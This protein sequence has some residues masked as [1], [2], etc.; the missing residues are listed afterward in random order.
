MGAISRA[1]ETGAIAHGYASTA[2]GSNAIALGVGSKATHANSVAIGKGSST[3]ASDQITFGTDN[4]SIQ[5]PG[6]TTPIDAYAVIATNSTGVLRV[7]SFAAANLP[8]SYCLTSAADATCYGQFAD[9]TGVST[10]AIGA[11]SNANSGTDSDS[12]FAATAIGAHTKATGQ[13][14]TALGTSARATG[15]GSVSTG[16]NSS[17]TGPG[18]LA[19]GYGSNATSQNTIAIG[20][21]ADAD[22]PNSYAIGADAVANG[23]GAIAIGSG[24]RALGYN[25]NALA[26]GSAAFANGTSAT[27]I[28]ASAFASGI[29]VTAIGAGARATHLGS[30]AIGAGSVTTREDQVV[31]GSANTDVTIPK[32]AGRGTSL[33]AANE[34]G[35]LRRTA[36]SLGQLDNAVNTQLPRLE[37][38]ARNLGQAVEAAGAMGAALSGLPEVSLGLNEPLR[39]G[40]GAGGWG[41]Q[42]SL[43]GGCAA[44]V[45]DRLH[46]NGAV[47]YTPQVNY[48]YGSTPTVG[49]RVGF[50][51]GFGGVGRNKAHQKLALSSRSPV[52]DLHIGDMQPNSP[53][54]QQVVIAK[55][56]RSDDA[57]SPQLEERADAQE[58]YSLRKRLIELERLI[59]SQT[60]GSV[61]ESSV[62]PS[63]FYSREKV[64]DLLAE[65]D[66]I[67][68]RL[69][70]RIETQEQLIKEQGAHYQKQISLQ[71]KI[72]ET[73][74]DQ[75]Q[76]LMTEVE[77]LKSLQRQ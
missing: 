62:G 40:F 4:T 27:S 10:T 14:S 55:S 76:L 7:A 44:R 72:L 63:S 11:Q 24:S 75:I 37:K 56:N 77:K 25:T 13:G 58:V 66:E 15:L 20:S 65:K 45:A 12:S 28:G 31:I 49:G 21:N 18:S 17:A 48:S 39:C 71:R 42:Y 38:A 59:F 70:A 19:Y 22:G 41:S 52:D 60:G 46:L 64:D 54:G 51:F 35:T 8:N 69:M 61:K 67:E 5:I 57:K 3:T 74:K 29:N 53:D 36:V 32:I 1:T 47:A 9:A 68:R 73:Q 34:D 43:A 23:V 6:L 2:S 50:S 30:T 16:M 33:L 26:V